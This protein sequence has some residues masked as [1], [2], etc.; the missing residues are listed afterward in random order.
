VR[1]FFGH[2]LVTL[3][4]IEA[5]QAEISQAKLKGCS[6]TMAFNE[7]QRPSTSSCTLN[8]TRITLHSR[9]LRSLAC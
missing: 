5:P 8:W 6:I 4:A 2:G 3:Y 9:S 7:G 1:P